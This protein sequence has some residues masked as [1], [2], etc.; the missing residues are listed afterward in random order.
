V[1]VSIPSSQPLLKNTFFS[2]F[3]SLPNQVTCLQN[4]SGF[5]RAEV[6]GW[7][8]A[9]WKSL[10]QVMSVHDANKVNK[11]LCYK[12]LTQWLSLN[13][14]Q[15]PQVLLSFFNRQQWT[16]LKIEYKIR[17]KSK[18]CEMNQISAK[19]LPTI[20]KSGC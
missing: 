1:F 3:D 18:F 11:M 9:C 2:L 13:C 6:K 5:H 12:Y 4:C 10:A 7:W 15:F 17:T 20:I 8:N 19:F 14:S 16:F